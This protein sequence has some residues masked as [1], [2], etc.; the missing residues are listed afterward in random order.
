MLGKRLIL[1]YIF[2]KNNNNKNLLDLV[3]FFNIY[4]FGVKVNVNFL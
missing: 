1:I 4:C 3:L 2:K